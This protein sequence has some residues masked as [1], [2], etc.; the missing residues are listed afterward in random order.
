MVVMKT[1]IYHEMFGCFGIIWPIGQIWHLFYHENM[2]LK[3]RVLRTC[4]STQ[5]YVHN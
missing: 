5:S 1:A 2:I 3:K 4:L